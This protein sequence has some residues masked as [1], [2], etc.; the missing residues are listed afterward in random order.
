MR[1][2][3]HSDQLVPDLGNVSL[4]TPLKLDVAA[5]LA[6]PDGSMKL[7]GLRCEITRGRLAYE[8]IAGKYYTTLGDIENMRRL[9]RVHA[10]ATAPVLKH[11]EMPAVAVGGVCSSMETGT[12]PQELLQANIKTCLTKSTSRTSVIQLLRHNPERHA[13]DIDQIPIAQVLSIYLC[14]HID[15]ESSRNDLSIEDRALI[16]CISRLNAYW[17]NITL[18]NVNTPAGKAYV[19][20]RINK[21][22]GRGGAR[23]DLEV[24]RAAINHHSKENLHYGN[25]NVWLPDRGEPRV[26]WLTRAEVARMIWAAYRYRE[27]QTIHVGPKKGQKVI[28]GRRPLRHVARFLLIGCY[29]GSRAGTIASAS[30][31]HAEGHSYVDLERGIFYRKPIGKR[32]TKKRQTTAPIPPRLLA[33]LRRWA[34]KGIAQEYFVE[35]NGRPVTSVKKAF[36]T[37]VTLAKIDTSIGAVVPHT[38]RHTAATW[39]MQNGTDIWDAAG[40][41]GMTV[42]VLERVYGH[43]HPDYQADAAER[44]TRRPKML[45]LRKRVAP[46]Q[47]N[48]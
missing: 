30:K 16:Q 25:V 10:T 1:K 6:F 36:R 2:K 8:M 12:S 39:L 19:K 17:G 35:F 33:H 11:N 3:A 44:I 20:H 28:T 37:V 40:Y 27:I 48:G 13:G 21:G 34:R 15:S 32:A 18:K 31:R 24:M 14:D 41:L 43:H 45:S 47:P 5:R 42:E 9:C 46:D 4:T 38:L 23:R 29:T 26:R 7:S 22:S